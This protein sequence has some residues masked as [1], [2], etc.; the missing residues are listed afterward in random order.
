MADRPAPRLADSFVCASGCLLITTVNSL[1]SQILVIITNAGEVHDL[2]YLFNVVLSN[3]TLLFY[4]ILSFAMLRPC[5]MRRAIFGP[6]KWPIW[7]GPVRAICDPPSRQTAN[8]RRPA[9][10]LNYRKWSAYVMRHGPFVVH[11][12][13]ANSAMLV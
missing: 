3:V 8:R 12:E 6:S 10:P 7:R 4:V 13:F 11:L 2:I 5:H 1:L 9:F